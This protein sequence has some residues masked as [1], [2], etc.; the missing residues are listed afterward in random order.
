MK[1]QIFCFAILTLALTG[2]HE[3]KHHTTNHT[4]TGQPPAPAVKV[5]PDAPEL[6]ETD[7]VTMTLDTLP[8]EAEASP[9]QPTSLKNAQ[10]LTPEEMN[11]PD[12]HKADHDTK[13]HSK[14]SHSE[15]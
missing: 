7:V 5:A 2:C 8:A 14:E 1:S 4:A 13:E 9:A 15:K 12:H 6:L 11:A 3:E 10:Q